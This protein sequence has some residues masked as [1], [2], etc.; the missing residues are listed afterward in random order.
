M[1]RSR[2]CAVLSPLHDQKLLN[3]DGDLYKYTKATEIMGDSGY[4][5]GEIMSSV[6]SG[7]TPAENA[8][9]NFGCI[10]SPYTRDSGDGTIRVFMDDDEY[11]VFEKIK[12]ADA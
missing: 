12:D 8:Q 1:R 4:V 2:A 9:S 11:H 6:E 10:G 3:V 7:E 5:A